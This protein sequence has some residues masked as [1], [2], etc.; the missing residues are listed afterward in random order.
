MIPNNTKWY[1]MTLNKKGLERTICVMVF[2]WECF[3]SGLFDKVMLKIPIADDTLQYLTIQKI[4]FHYVF[5]PSQYLITSNKLGIS[6][7]H[8]LSPIH[9]VSSPIWYQYHHGI[10]TLWYWQF[11]ICLV[12]HD[13]DSGNLELSSNNVLS[14]YARSTIVKSS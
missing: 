10:I 2:C 14:L 9:W 5:T 6:W 4:Y 7:S 1:N 8:L 3:W 13:T 11:W 12:H